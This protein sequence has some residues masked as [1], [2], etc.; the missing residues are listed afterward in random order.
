VEPHSAVPE[1]KAQE[2][3]P[4]EA[5]DPLP[6]CHQAERGDLRNRGEWK[7]VPA[8]GGKQIPSQSPSPPQLLLSN[9]YR[10][11]EYEGLANED[12]GEGPSGGLPRTSWS[13]P[14]IMTAPAK[15]KR[16]VN[17]IG[18]SLLRGTEGP[19]CRP[20]PSHRE[21][22]CLPGV[23]VRDV[24]RKLPGLVWPSDY[25]LLLVMQVGG[26]KIREKSEGHQKGLQ[27]T[28]WRQ[29]ESSCLKEE[30]RFLATSWRGSLRGL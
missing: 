8:W 11:L 22:C 18:D 12:A 20:D 2:A 16:R 24:A 30:K 27:G 25:Y 23:Q 3:A 15:K 1:A 29:M 17:A 7:R 10:A 9:R 13:A 21:V 26:D 5:E 28:C 19:V 4:Q 14:S 6:S